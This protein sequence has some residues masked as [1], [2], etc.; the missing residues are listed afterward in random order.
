VYVP[1]AGISNL[2][3]SKKT[4]R[5]KNP[6]VLALKESQFQGSEAEVANWK[7]LP[8]NITDCYT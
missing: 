6:E 7:Q 3:K 4:P 2:K 8:K 1:V 5:K